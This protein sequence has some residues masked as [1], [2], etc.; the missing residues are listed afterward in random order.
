MQ[1]DWTSPDMVKISKIEKWPEMSMW[2]LN[3]CVFKMSKKVK[4]G[5]LRK[6]F[7]KNASNK[8]LTYIFHQEE[9]ILFRFLS[10]QRSSWHH[11]DTVPEAVHK[12]WDNVEY[13][14]AVEE[15]TKAD[16]ETGYICSRSCWDTDSWGWGC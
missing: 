1:A 5:L 3:L 7:E 6:Q 12:A 2:I 10:L 8:F 11:T 13:P 9:V 14:K 16:N 4:I 15:A